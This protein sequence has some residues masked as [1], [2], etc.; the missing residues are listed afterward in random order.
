MRVFLKELA[1]DVASLLVVAGMIWL[2][3]YAA[4]IIEALVNR[5]VPA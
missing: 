2:A 5:S 3:M 1:Q 4:P